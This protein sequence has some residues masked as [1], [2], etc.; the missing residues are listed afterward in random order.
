MN[1]FNRLSIV[2]IYNRYP[3][4]T[5]HHFDK[6]T[7]V[8]EKIEVE[9]KVIVQESPNQWIEGEVLQKTSRPKSFV[10]KTI[11]DERKI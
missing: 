3:R 9:S 8:K 1:R 2:I 7:C 6:S 11:K 4:L 10:I 5:K